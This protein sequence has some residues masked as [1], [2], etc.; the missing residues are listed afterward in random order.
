MCMVMWM[1]R[2]TVC[3]LPLRDPQ[4]GTNGFYLRVG[5]LCHKSILS[6]ANSCLDRIQAGRSKLQIILAV[7]PI[8]W[9]L[10]VNFCWWWS[11]LYLNKMGPCGQY[12]VPKKTLVPSISLRGSSMTLR[13]GP[14]CGEDLSALLHGSCAHTRVNGA[15]RYVVVTHMHAILKHILLSGFFIFIFQEAHHNKILI[16]MSIIV[17]ISLNSFSNKTNTL[18]KAYCSF[19]CPYNPDRHAMVI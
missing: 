8:G 16:L 10:Q 7:S 3:I 4:V 14:M 11:C 6:I 15:R 17:S 9:S 12:L 13:F 2:Q 19:I 18:I 5:I 1:K